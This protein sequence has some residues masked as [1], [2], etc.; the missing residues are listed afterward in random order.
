MIWYAVERRRGR[1]WIEVDRYLEVEDA[2]EHARRLAEVR[3]RGAVRISAIRPGYNA[4]PP[5]VIRPSTS[6]QA[7]TLVVP[8]RPWVAVVDEV[9]G[10]LRPSRR[11]CAS[12]AEAEG[13]AAAMAAA[14]GRTWRVYRL[15]PDG[16]WSSVSTFGAE[17]A[18]QRGVG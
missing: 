5:P 13:H 14:T 8:A 2:Q 9:L 7:P 4:W 10:S 12:Q 17:A 11:A 3:G 16:R 1:G 6:P 15:S 18:E